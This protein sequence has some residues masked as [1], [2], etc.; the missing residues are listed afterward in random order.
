VFF[1]R[2]DDEADRQAG[3]AAIAAAGGNQQPAALPPRP[4]PRPRHPHQ[5]RPPPRSRTAAAVAAMQY[6]VVAPSG[7]KWP[8][9][10]L[11]YKIR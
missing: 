9:C 6:F 8:L 3:R 4:Q 10:T 2:E 7:D 5:N 11:A 1:Q